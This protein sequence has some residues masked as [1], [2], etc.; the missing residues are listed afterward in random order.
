[1]NPLL[2][3]TVAVACALAAWAS[4]AVAQRWRMQYFY[5]E[6]KSELVIDDIAFPSSIRGVAVGRIREGSH[7]RGVSLATS[8]GG[9]HWKASPLDD[10]PLSLFFLSDAVGWMVTEK[11]LWRSAEA[12]K[13]WMKLPKVPA[14]A[15]RVFFAD[16]KRGWAACGNK[17]VLATLDGG[18][19]WVKVAEAAEQPGA[20]AGSAYGWIA[21][22]TPE[23]GIITG[24]DI[25]PR[26]GRFPDWLD[27]ARVVTRREIPR[28]T[29][30]LETHDGGKTWKSSSSSMFGEITRIRFGSPGRGLGLVSHS[31]SF[32][33]PSEAYRILWPTGSSEIAYRD[34]DF[35]A[36]DAW[37]APNG[38]AYLA[39][40]AAFSKLRD[41]VPQKVRVLKSNNFKDWTPI[42]VD[43][44]A[45][46]K[47]VTLA[48]SGG[49]LWLATD[50]GMILKLEP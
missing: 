17:T 46:A 36:T 26:F 2:A 11:G 47:R 5:D 7:E 8:D 42:P 27:P 22:A 16:E 31:A 50:N 48:G 34:K 3:R 21:F 9:A 29:L 43:Y 18:A 37:I 1:M 38:T 13:D 32:Q 33:F 25:P 41:Y 28:L 19:H 4:T 40:I 39:G 35:Y 24:W 30:A 23:I 49:D 6:A 10:K 44:R 20:T 14:P 12:G 15:L 45:V